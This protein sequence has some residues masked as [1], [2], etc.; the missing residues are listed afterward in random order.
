MNPI[1]ND[2]TFYPKS[3]MHASSGLFKIIDLVA[4]HISLPD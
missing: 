2:I 1:E 3:V 4:Y